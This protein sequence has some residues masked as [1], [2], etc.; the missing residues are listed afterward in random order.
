MNSA[1]DRKDFLFISCEGKA[2]RLRLLVFWLINCM[3]ATELMS[4]HIEDT[5]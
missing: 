5:L 4:K 1:R 3:K 2:T